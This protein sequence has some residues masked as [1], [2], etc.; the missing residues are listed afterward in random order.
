MRAIA[1]IAALY[2]I[3][4]A[5]ASDPAPAFKTVTWTGWFSDFDCASSTS[6]A[7]KLKP[8]NPVCAEACI[9]KGVPP[10]FISEQAKAVFKV[11]DYPSVIEDLGYHIEVEGRVDEQANTIQILSVKRMEYVGA[12][13]ARP[14]KPA[15]GK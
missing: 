15:A 14:R 9:R 10:V 5:L 4:A 3:H 13:C 1:L 12:A 7:E 8:T 2:L 11:K 6:A